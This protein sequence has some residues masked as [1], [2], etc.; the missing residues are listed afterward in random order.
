MSVRYSTPHVHYPQLSSSQVCWPT[1][2]QMFKCHI[3]V[4]VCVCRKNR[5]YE[6]VWTRNPAC[7]VFQLFRW[8]RWLSFLSV[9]SVFVDFSFWMRLG[10]QYHCYYLYTVVC[11]QIWRNVLP[12][13]F[14]RYTLQGSKRL[15]SVP[16]K[17]SPIYLGPKNL[18]IFWCTGWAWNCQINFRCASIHG[19]AGFILISRYI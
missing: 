12:F 5:G 1:N 17:S 11:Q 2:F 15:D 16:K 13:F 6:G 7:V 10:V 4:C 19:R 14:P 3:C 9:L 18:K 8:L